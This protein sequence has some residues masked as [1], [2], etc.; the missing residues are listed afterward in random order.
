M[1]NRGAVEELIPPVDVGSFMGEGNAVSALFSLSS[2]LAAMEPRLHPSRHQSLQDPDV[3]VTVVLEQQSETHFDA[4]C[5]HSLFPQFCR[6]R[7]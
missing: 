5:P 2:F 4:T 3:E 7:H 1:S 6:C